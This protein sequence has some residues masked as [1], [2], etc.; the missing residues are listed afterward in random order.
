MMPV[1]CHH[2][3]RPADRGQE[4]G[5]G[6]RADLRRRSGA[7]LSVMTWQADPAA[8]A[9]DR[10][11]APPVP[12]WRPDM[13]RRRAAGDG[14]AFRRT[15]D[16][17]PSPRAYHDPAPRCA[18]RPRPGWPPPAGL[19][20]SRGGCG[21]RAQASD[22]CDSLP[23]WQGYPAPRGGRPAALGGR[24][25]A[26][27]G[28]PAAREDRPAVREDRPAVREDRPAKPVIRRAVSGGGR[29]AA[30]RS[31]MRPGAGGPGAGRRNRQRRAGPA[32]PS[33]RPVS[34]LCAVNNRMTR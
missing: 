30:V 4:C 17:A 13:C 10:C 15:G 24:P 25:A 32:L 21:C 23:G 2:R 33:L 1:S 16:A 29:P 19:C 27:G 7:G 9:G 11:V 12:G 14:A 6:R 22:Q 8:R 3:S 18:C 20:P 34:N 28:R 31:C 26:R 5:P